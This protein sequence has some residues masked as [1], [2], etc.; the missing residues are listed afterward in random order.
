MSKEAFVALDADHRK[1]VF[2]EAVTEVARMVSVTTCSDALLEALDD[3]VHV[4]A[5]LLKAIVSRIMLLTGPIAISTAQFTSSVTASINTVT[6]STAVSHT[7][8][9]SS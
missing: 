8:Y 6:A 1:H 3:C 4:L 9:C 7:Y 5:C 2:K